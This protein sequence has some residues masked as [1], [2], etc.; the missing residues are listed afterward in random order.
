[1]LLEAFEKIP[2]PVL[3]ID[4]SGK[5]EAF[6]EAF[7]RWSNRDLKVGANIAD[8]LSEDLYLCLHELILKA[9]KGEYLGYRAHF[10]GKSIV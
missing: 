6:S 5:I 2:S 7:T 10:L 1:M 9:R 8:Q 3:L 4:K